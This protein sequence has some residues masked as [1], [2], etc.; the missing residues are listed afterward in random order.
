MQALEHLI[1]ELIDGKYRMDKLLGRGGMGAVFLATHMGTDRPVAVKVIMPQF[2]GSDEFVSRFQREARAAGRL[3]HPNV[4]NVTDFGFARVNNERIAYLVM[5][6]LDGCTLA[7]VLAEESQLPLDWV[8]DILEQACSA[9][10]EAHRQGIVHRDLKPDNIWLEPNRRGGYTVKVLDF[11]LAKLA[12]PT[13]PASAPAAN[14][15]QT[16]SLPPAAPLKEERPSLAAVTLHLPSVPTDALEAKTQLQSNNKATPLTDALEAATQLQPG[17]KPTP[18]ADALEATT[19]LQPA[20]KVAA[21]KT[22]TGA[23][24]EEHTLMLPDQPARQPEHSSARQSAHDTQRQ[25]EAAQTETT[26]G[27]TRVGSIMGTPL[28]MSPEQCRGEALDARSDIYNLGVIAYQML[29]GETPF[30]GDMPTVM[31]L[32]IEAPPPP[33]IEKRKDIPKKVAQVVMSALA[34]NPNERPAR[35]ASFAS[36][37]SAYAERPGKLLRRA[38]ALYSENFSTFT[39]LALINFTPWILLVLAQATCFWLNYFKLISHGVFTILAVVLGIGNVICLSLGSA[40]MTGIVA[41]LVTQLI[42]APLAPIKL[43][44]A[45]TALRQRLRPFITTTLRV[46]LTVALGMILLIIPGIIFMLMYHLVTP[47]IMIEGL[48]GKAARIRSK[49][50][51]WRARRIVLMTIGIQILLPMLTSGLFSLLISTNIAL[52]AKFYQIPGGKE[53]MGSVQSVVNMPFQVLFAII[54]AIITALL[55]LTTRQAGGETLKEALSL[56]E[57]EALPERKWQQRMRDRRLS[58]SSHTR[59]TSQG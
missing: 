55:Y 15:S 14:S 45:F 33:L 26:D 13:P 27:L 56:F 9:L 28:Y 46:A 6:Y 41:R 48:S 8:V 57:D 52:L 24:E 19:Q 39:K 25:R 49:T 18:V 42:A 4:V 2:M 32:H 23:D 10:D 54:S 35:A 5:E 30:K 17:S 3:R 7:E 31:K 38:I 36:A 40:F 53:I 59:P 16:S 20:N 44:P 1:G 34:K 58:S 12:D 51:A 37:L 50:L 21:V 43:R 11:G 22:P 29:A 47:V